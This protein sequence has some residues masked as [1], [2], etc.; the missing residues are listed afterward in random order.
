MIFFVVWIVFGDLL[1]DV[2]FVGEY[3]VQWYCVNFVGGVEG[4]FDGFGL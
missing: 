4:L 3:D 2:F 1:V